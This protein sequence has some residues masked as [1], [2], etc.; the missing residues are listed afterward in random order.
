MNTHDYMLG[1]IAFR[2][3]DRGGRLRGV[4]H[5]PKDQDHD[6][7]GAYARA[8]I[9]SMAANG[10][11]LHHAMRLGDAR[12]M[13]TW[14]HIVVSSFLQAVHDGELTKPRGHWTVSTE[15]LE[16]TLRREVPKWGTAGA[17]VASVLEELP[18]AA[19][20][21][22]RAFRA[23]VRFLVPAADTEIGERIVARSDGNSLRRVFVDDYAIRSAMQEAGISFSDGWTPVVN[24]A[25]VLRLQPKGDPHRNTFLMFVQGGYPAFV[26]VDWGFSWDEMPTQLMKNARMVTEWADNP[27]VTWANTRAHSHTVGVTYDGSDPIEVEG[28][29]A[30]VSREGS[31][32]R[33][34]GDVYASDLI[35]VARLIENPI[36][37]RF[38]ASLPYVFADKLKASV[39]R[40]HAEYRT[41]ALAKKRLDVDLGSPRWHEWFQLV[42]MLHGSTIAGT[43]DPAQRAAI[44]KALKVPA[45]NAAKAAIHGLDLVARDKH[46]RSK[47][48]RWD[49]G[50]SDYEIET[51]LSEVEG[52][53]TGIQS[54]VNA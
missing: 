34:T 37:R 33:R 53:A 24:G 29:A 36:A 6:V 5:M 17:L 43:V 18:A 52:F 11:S 23:E 16:A 54:I 2:L 3:A 44:Y 27:A 49:T 15:A 46:P 28:L 41:V 32:M 47:R 12:G 10:M 7:V 51:A 21:A 25:S 8:A 48:T 40:L 19:T 30:D 45:K 4:L 42:Q 1:R 20:K 39:D 22:L 38:M 31:N 26:A 50:M 9:G 14:D 35:R 13:E